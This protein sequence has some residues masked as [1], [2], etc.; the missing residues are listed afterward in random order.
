M[1]AHL[2][3]ATLIASIAAGV[4]LLLRRRSAGLRHAILLAALLGFAAPTPWLNQ[5]G[6]RLATFLAVKPAVPALLDFEFRFDIASLPKTPAKSQ[7]R[8]GARNAGLLVWGS[9]FALVL[10]AWLRRLLRTVRQVREPNP[11]EAEALCRGKEGLHL[12]G[13]VGL[14][15][16]TADRVPGARGWL[17]P[18]VVL[19]EGLSEQLSEAELSAMVA[20]EL[21]H[22]VRR[23]NLSAAVARV[24]VSAF[25]FHPLV[26]WIERRMLMER[27]AACDELVLAHGAGREDYIS[28]ILKVCGLSFTGTSGY[29]GA[30]GSNLQS[31][32]EQIMTA[33]IDLPSSRPPSRRFSNL[34]RAIPGAIV[35]LSVLLPAA[36]GFLRGQGPTPATPVHHSA[37][38]AAAARAYQSFT[39]GRF[40]EA[41][42]LFRQ[43]YLQDPQDLRGVAGLTESYISENR[44]DEAVK[45]LQQE[46]AKYPGQR[47]LAKMLGNV[48]VRTEQYDLAIA[49]FQGLLDSSPKPPPE[50]TAGLLFRLGE[51]YRRKGD[52]NAAIPAFRAA[53]AANPKETSPLL[54]LA[55]ILDGTG[56]GEQAVP[57]YEQILKLQPDNAVALNNLA[58]IVAQKGDD[59]DRALDLAERAAQAHKDSP[60]IQ[61]TLGWAYLKKNRPD[62]AR[63]VF[64][65]LIEKEPQNPTF[66]YHLG[67]ALLQTGDRDGA[68]QELKTALANGLPQADAGT[69]RELLE[70]IAP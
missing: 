25:W 24:I 29:A 36:G 42:E 55:L 49:L 43:L 28:A 15:I 69:V 38:D 56:R 2:I 63:A 1:I 39:Q 10:A 21:A 68:I 16:T 50:E 54:A 53:A 40:Q 23:D 61:D 52:L 34:L 26:W 45:L 66:H 32:M 31:R 27:E 41:E 33:G 6:G 17:R 7:E 14:C 64:Q 22:I 30:T 35:T 58:Y 4:A 47:E 67:M 57:V 19:P 60:D 65:A 59:P 9:V 48:Y 12:D 3:A 18:C 13:R 70:K 5:A 46:A 20:H 62:E 8:G 37:N 11:A 51:A 44:A